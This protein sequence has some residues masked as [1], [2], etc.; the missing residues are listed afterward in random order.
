MASRYNTRGRPA[1]VLVQ[2][3]AFELINKRETFE[4]QIAGEQIPAFLA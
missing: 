1:E 3:S 2:D 4:D